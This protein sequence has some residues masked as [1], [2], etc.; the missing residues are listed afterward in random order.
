MGVLAKYVQEEGG[1][2]R[3]NHLKIHFE[4]PNLAHLH[5]FTL[6]CTYCVNLYNLVCPNLLVTACQGHIKEVF[7]LPKLLERRAELVLK[8]IPPK[9]EFFCW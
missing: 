6:M 8:I 9:T 7:V 2:G 5:F 3:K 1:A 4:F